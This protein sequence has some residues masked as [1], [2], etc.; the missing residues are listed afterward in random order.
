MD[1][2]D[3][4]ARYA[5]SAFLVRYFLDNED[6]RNSTAFMAYLRLLSTLEVVDPLELP[7]NLA[8]DWKEIESKFA[9][10]LANKR[11]PL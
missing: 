9:R 1:P 2:I 6:S 3:R 11:V 4:E 7:E 5:K 10:W 8:S